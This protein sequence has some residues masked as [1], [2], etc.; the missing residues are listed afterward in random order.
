VGRATLLRAAGW[1]DVDAEGAAA[2][3]RVVLAHTKAVL[4][5]SGIDRGGEVPG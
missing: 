4:T 2:I 5:D 3:R 1:T